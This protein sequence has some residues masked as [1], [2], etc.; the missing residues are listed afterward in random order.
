MH[1]MNISKIALSLFA[2]SFL[3]SSCIK[4]KFETPP[5]TSQ[6]DPNL[7]VNV[8]VAQLNNLALKMGSGQFRTLGDSTIYG[9]VT[10]DDR[11]GNF[12]KQL[13][14]QDSTGGITVGIAQ[15][16]LYEDYPI[17]RKV[18]I[19]L[20]GLIL[21]NYNGLPEIMFSATVAA[22]KTTAIGVPITLIPTYIYKASY[23]N[24][25]NPILMRLDDLIQNPTPYLNR[26]VSI[27]NME[28]DS[29]VVGAQYA[30]PSLL[31]I[32]TS[33]TL[34]PCPN[35]NNSSLIV[36][37]SGYATFQPAVLPAGKGNLVGIFSM[38]N[39]IQFLIRDTTDVQFTQERDCR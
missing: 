26:L 15:T 27:E 7:P 13:V 17:G 11:S 30:L 35:P 8:T 37:N 34:H 31:A 29:S 2:C 12:Y 6:Y 21:V 19:K 23:P 14:I 18:Y 28:F 25:V 39:S 4:Q 1:I 32:S 10:A 24:V 16:N 33:R 22:G 3:L 20:G 36:Y 5:D 9:I 38:Y